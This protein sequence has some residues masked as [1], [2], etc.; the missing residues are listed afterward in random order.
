M[1]LKNVLKLRKRRCNH[2][3]HKATKVAQKEHKIKF[4]IKNFMV[5]EL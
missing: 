4:F 5:E 2:K 1:G 3:D